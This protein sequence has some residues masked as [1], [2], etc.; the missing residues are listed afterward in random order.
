M[1][2]PHSTAVTFGRFNLLHIGHLELFHRMAKRADKVVIGISSAPAN[3]P[4]KARVEIIAKALEPTNIEVEIQDGHQPFEVFS[5]CPKDTIVYLGED[6][7]KLARA[8]TRTLGFKHEVIER[9]ASSTQVRQLINDEEW[10]LLARIVPGSVMRDVI[11]LH[12]YSENSHAKV[13][14]N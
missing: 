10:D 4:I 11:N 8:V 1:D 13:H 2:K 5:Q 14:A 9:L 7:V 6:Q 12:L 3:L